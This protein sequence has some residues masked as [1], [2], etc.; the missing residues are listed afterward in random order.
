[1]T[2]LQN[3][4]SQKIAARTGRSS[5]ISKNIAVSYWLPEYQAMKCSIM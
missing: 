2:T 5:A 3:T 4:I 1:M